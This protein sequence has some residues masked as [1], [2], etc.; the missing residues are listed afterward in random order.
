MGICH[1]ICA[2]LTR[3]I[4]REGQILI[5]RTATFNRTNSATAIGIKNN[6]VVCSKSGSDCN[7]R[8]LDIADCDGNVRISAHGSSG[9]YPACEANAAKSDGSKAE[10]EKANG[11]SFRNLIHGCSPYNAN[12][13]KLSFA[14][15]VMVAPSKAVYIA[16]SSDRTISA[17]AAVFSLP[18]RLK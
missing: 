2:S 11:F 9:N 5:R 3:D 4:N 8:V 12:Y 15:R 17:F 14:S 1:R 6:F 10:G 18:L 7:T 13:L 16:A